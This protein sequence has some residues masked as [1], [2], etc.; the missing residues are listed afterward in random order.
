MH[1]AVD[2][3]LYAADRLVSTSAVSGGLLMKGLNLLPCWWSPSNGP[4]GAS[5]YDDVTGSRCW[6]SMFLDARTADHSW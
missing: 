4:S 5:W 2:D 1:K 3:A 6:S